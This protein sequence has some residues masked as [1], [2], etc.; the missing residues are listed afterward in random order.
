MEGH[1]ERMEDERLANKPELDE[2]C[3]DPESD[4]PNNPEGWALEVKEILGKN[5]R[6]FHY[7]STFYFRATEAWIWLLTFT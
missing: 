5:T 2:T 4:G 3:V 7:L 6:A 1:L